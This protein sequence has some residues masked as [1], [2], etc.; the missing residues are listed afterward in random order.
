MRWLP[1]VALVLAGVTTHAQAP[2]RIATTPEAL[3]A[4]PVFFHGKQIA[5]RATVTDQG[6]LARLDVPTTG[7]Q[8]TT[9]RDVFVIWKDRP[10]GG[11]GE[12]RGDFWDLGRLT[13]DDSR[14]SSYDFRPILEA[15]TNG[16]WPAR[17]QVFVI[18]NAA[19][20]DAPPPPAPTVR[21]I[22]M[23]PYRYASQRV[24]VTGRFRGR[25]LYG[26][27]PAPL[28]R[29]KWDFVI[30]SADAAVWVSGVRPR[31]K[32]FDLDPG[33][34]ADT[35]RWVEV[36]GTV[37]TEGTR[38]WIEGVAIQLATPPAET[39]VEITVPV[40]A[41]EPPPAVI[42][43]APVPDEVDVE[44]T[45]SIRIQFSRGLD[46]RSLKD[47]IRV[48]YL[49]PAQGEPPAPPVFSFAYND[50]LNAV[51]IKFAKPL[52]RFHRIKVEL[53]EGI[54][55]TDG[56]ALMPWTLTFVTGG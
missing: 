38:A 7:D 28:N 15:T 43:S 55:A 29:S 19:R 9:V 40:V 18:L 22:A 46:S 12:I 42:F 13:A 25:N 1:A 27:L 24:T 30:Q 33:L 47:R 32:D 50:G 45:T 6:G 31:G 49:P 39:P 52:E 35:G 37:Q 10:S 14:F 16:G 26:D 8:R 44:P 4:S 2:G 23:D 17:D 48:A 51:Q 11:D 41:K 53:L 5:V 3:L 20:V 36:S 54:T 56:Q 34:R 21:A